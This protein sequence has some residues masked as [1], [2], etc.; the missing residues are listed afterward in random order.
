MH[1]HPRHIYVLV[2]C[3]YVIIYIFCFNFYSVLN[4]I[5]TMET[6]SKKNMKQDVYTKNRPQ[7]LYSHV[8]VF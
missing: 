2:T 8:V 6:I 5:F 1:Q 4:K 7:R 3:I